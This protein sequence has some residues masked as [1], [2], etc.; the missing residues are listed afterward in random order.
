MAFPQVSSQ[1]FESTLFSPPEKDLF[2]TTSQQ[3]LQNPREMT[4]VRK[5]EKMAKIHRLYPLLKDMQNAKFSKIAKICQNAWAIAFAKCSVW[6]KNLNS[7][8]GVKN[9]SR[10][11][12]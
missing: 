11:T 1:S 9:D 2:L 5:S 4:N 12:L 8:K 7:K 6:V 10:S 3:P